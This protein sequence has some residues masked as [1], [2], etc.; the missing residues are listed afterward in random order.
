VTAGRFEVR[1][2]DVAVSDDPAR[3]DLAAVHGFL[4]AS[5]WAAGIPEEVVRRSI[6]GSLCFGLYRSAPGEGAAESQ[7][8]FA[9]AVTDRATYAY[10]ADVYVREEERGRGLGTFLLE[11]VMAHP[12]LQGL[13]RWSLVTRDAHALYRKL[14]FTPLAVPAGHMERVEADLYRRAAGGPLPG[15]ISGRI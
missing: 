3:L 8:G 2:G 6:A 13:R 9:R 5:Y 14:G 10:L 15:R 4:A 1:R 11:A 12:D 7:L